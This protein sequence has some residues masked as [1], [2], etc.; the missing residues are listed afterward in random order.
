[1]SPPP[2]SFLMRLSP[3]C[4]QPDDWRVL[5]PAAGHTA[6]HASLKWRDDASWLVGSQSAKRQ[7][8]VYQIPPPDRPPPQPPHWAPSVRPLC[9]SSLI[10]VGLAFRI[11]R[12]PNAKCGADVQ[13]QAA[14]ANLIDDGFSPLFACF[15]SSTV[16]EEY[17]SRFSWVKQKCQHWD[18]NPQRLFFEVFPDRDLSSSGEILSLCVCFLCAWKDWSLTILL[19]KLEGR[20]RDKAP[21]L[22]EHAILVCNVGV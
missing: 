21:S 1:M 8:Y 4:F 18:S 20:S 17:A 10:I 19:H 3:W 16:S 11:F 6:L 13:S 22:Q 7:A 15:Q 2:D 14:D 5:A 12:L 9:W